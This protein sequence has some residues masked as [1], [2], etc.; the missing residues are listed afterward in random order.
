MFNTYGYGGYLINYHPE[1]R[2]FI[3]GRGDLY[4]LG[5]AFA[6]FVQIRQLKPAAF[7][8]LRSYGIRACILGRGEALAV[9]LAERPDWQRIYSDEE[10]VIFVLRDSPAPV[11]KNRETQANLARSGHE[12]PAD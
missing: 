7:S 3:D 5:G 12:S 2:V 8:I 4:E 6:E 10:S 1:E 9:V 11:A